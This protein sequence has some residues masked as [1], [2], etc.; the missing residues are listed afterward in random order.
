[1]RP[2]V[3]IIYKGKS[4][5]ADGYRFCPIPEVAV[6]PKHPH[7]NLGQPGLGTPECLYVTGPRE[8]PMRILGL[9]FQGQAWIRKPPGSGTGH[10]GHT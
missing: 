10:D 2:Y 6:A 4:S 9:R 3:E 8:W 1:V 5:L 7:R